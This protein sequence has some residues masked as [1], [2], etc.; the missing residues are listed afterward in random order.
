MHDPLPGDEVLERPV[1]LWVA[2]PVALGV[3]IGALLGWAF[4]VLS[5]R[6]ATAPGEAD[7][8]WCFWL[9]LSM[10]VAGAL[11]VGAGVAVVVVLTV[12]S[13]REARALKARL[14]ATTTAG[15]NDDTTDA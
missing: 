15:G 12:R 7:P 2:L 13:L 5:C 4:G 11:L 6:A 1:P 9:E 3:A 8:A 10:A 14:A